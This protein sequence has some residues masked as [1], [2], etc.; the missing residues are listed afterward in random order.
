VRKRLRSFLSFAVIIAILIAALKIINWVPMAIQEG[1]IRKYDS[2]EDV[3]LKLKIRDLYVPSYFPQSLSWPPAEILAQSK[4]F[5]AI[6][7]EFKRVKKGDVALIISQA[8]TSGDFTPD[9]KIKAA[10][11]RETIHYPLKGREAV[12]EVGICKNDEPYSKISW[13]EG[14][15]KITVIMKSM[16]QELIRIAESMI[17][18][19]DET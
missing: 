14:K 8:D 15:Y 11:I 10:H 4:P 18:H 2:I 13:N 19:P 6:I 17:P 12:L 7:M 16:P 5:T 9:M 1:T 3:R